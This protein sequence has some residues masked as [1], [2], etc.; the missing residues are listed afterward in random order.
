MSLTEKSAYI[1]GLAEGL[2]L[3]KTSKEGKVIAALLE[4]VDELAQAV[5]EVR[6][7]IEEIDEDLDYLNEYIEEIDED[8]SLL[9][10]LVKLEALSESLDICGFFGQIHT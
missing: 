5:S 10:G 6:K 7:D 4:L 9:G 2:E 8:L 3:D 1:K